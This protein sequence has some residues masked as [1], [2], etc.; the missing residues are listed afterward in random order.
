MIV[1]ADTSPL[2][3]IILIGAADVLQPLYTSVVVPQTVA[4]ELIASRTPP[5]VR[6]WIAKRPAWLHI[7]PDP[8]SDPTLSALDPGERAA[9]AL[10]VSVHASR[11]LIDDFDGRAEAER[12]SLRVTGTLGVLVAAHRSGLLDFNEAVARLSNTT[13]IY[14]PG[15][16]PRC[17]SG[18]RCRRTGRIV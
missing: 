9:I 10:A 12:R 13:S 8:P 6:T 1:V 3:Y 16:L 15:S 7:L 17:G 11:L 14:P 5:A 2:N 18:C 4:D